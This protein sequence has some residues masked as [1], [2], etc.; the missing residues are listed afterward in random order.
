[1]AQERKKSV[2][3]QRKQTV[4]QSAGLPRDTA[5][6]DTTA[7]LDLEY[8]AMSTLLRVPSEDDLR[9]LNRDR[10]Q[11]LPEGNLW[12]IPDLDHWAKVDGPK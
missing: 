6:S 9:E 1:M 12:G 7:V 2:A 5:V 10:T 8:E 4:R 11:P 3:E